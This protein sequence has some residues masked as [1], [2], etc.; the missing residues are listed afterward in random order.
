MP[1]FK[2]LRSR[3][4]NFKLSALA[5]KYQVI[6]IT[7]TGLDG[8]ILDFELLESYSI[9]HSDKDYAAL[10][11]PIGGCALIVVR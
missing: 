10:G 11:K 3:V 9:F 4:S 8:E 1:D 6:C 5:V 2:S 7:E